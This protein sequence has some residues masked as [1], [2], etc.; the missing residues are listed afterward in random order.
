M[1]GYSLQE[2]KAKLSELGLSPKRALGQNFLINKLSCEKIAQAVKETKAES[3]VEVGPGLGAITD[4][5]IEMNKPLLVME[6]DRGFCEMWRTRGVEVVEGDAL[7]Y[8]WKNLSL[9][10]PCTLVS[11]LPYQ[12]S[13]RIVIDRSLEPGPIRHMI[14]MFQKEVA[15]RMVSGHGTKEYGLLSVVA[16]SAWKIHKLFEIS[17]KDFFPPPAVASRVLVFEFKGRPL[18]RRYLDL[19]KVAFEQRRKMLMPNLTKHYPEES[20]HKAFERLGLNVKC[21]AE[22]LT[23]QQF[24]EIYRCVHV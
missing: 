10:A 6:L 20:I 8:D 16:Q 18:D 21:R 12:I 5:L 7:H 15:E 24:E 2:V 3:F 19:V 1:S 4:L 11:N 14:L 13:S 22:E 17:S 9:Q 23:P